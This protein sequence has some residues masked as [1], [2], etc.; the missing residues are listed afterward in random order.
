MKGLGRGL[1]TS[2]SGGFSFFKFTLISFHIFSKF[3]KTAFGLDKSCGYDIIMVYQ[4][5]L[6]M[7]E[8]FK[9]IGRMLI[10]VIVLGLVFFGGTTEPSKQGGAFATIH[11][12]ATLFL[13][14]GFL[15]G[16]QFL[17]AILFIAPKKAKKTL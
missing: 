8:K 9:K 2:H 11:G 17:I 10:W 16:L 14:Y 5:V 3:P 1:Y 15:A 6:N 4:E 7:N 12:L 13:F